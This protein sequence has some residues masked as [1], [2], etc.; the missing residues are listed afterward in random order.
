MRQHARQTRKN[1]ARFYLRF[2]ATLYN[3][4][5]MSA[6]YYEYLVHIKPR[7]TCLTQLQKVTSCPNFSGLKPVAA[8]SNSWG[9][10]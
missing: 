9:S 6:C 1:R 2:C 4:Q 3:V 5:C 7:S 8:T 10:K